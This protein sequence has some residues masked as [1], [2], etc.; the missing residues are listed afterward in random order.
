[1]GSI[2]D[3]TN[4]NGINNNFDYLFDGVATM[5]NLNIK[6]D[7]TLLKADAVLMNA[8]NINQSNVD[9]QNQLDNI[10]LESGTSDAEV[11]QSRT[12]SNGNTYPLLK[13][14][15]NNIDKSILSRGANL[16]D[17]GAV[18]DGV[19]DDTDALKSML[20][21]DFNIFYIPDKKY[22]IKEKIEIVR[23]N[24]KIISDG[25]L[26]FELNGDTCF[27]V[28]G[29]NVDLILKIDGNNLA[30][31]GIK[32]TGTNI[33]VEKSNLYNFYSETGTAY[34]VF[35]NNCGRV[36]I[37]NNNISSVHSLGNGTTGDSIGASRGVW[38]TNSQDNHTDGVVIKD[39]NIDGIIGEEGDAIH[40]IN[41]LPNP[42][43]KQMV[44]VV[45]GNT[46]NNFSRRGIKI[47]A[48]DVQVSNNIFKEN[49]D[50]STHTARVIDVI[51]SSDVVVFNNY[52]KT[53]SLNSIGVTTDISVDSETLVFSNVFT[54]LNA[55]TMLYLSKAKNVTFNSNT[56]Y[57]V[58]RFIGIDDSINVSFTNNTFESEQTGGSGVGVN[59]NSL[60]EKIVFKSNLFN[61]GHFDWTFQNRSPNSVI[62]DNISTTE[63][64]GI[65]TFES[66]EG[67]LY[68][69]NVFNGVEVYGA[70]ST[71][72][73]LKSYIQTM[74]N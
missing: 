67:S 65:R 31:G 72:H 10:I 39:N 11:V 62:S 7:A 28:T 6:A 1:M 16:I 53:K 20:E 44:S 60:S 2:W 74:V 71:E 47:Q 26:N 41:G 45:T 23:S 38:V 54:Q 58:G 13:D 4:R 49:L 52:V 21:S 35:A 8:Q 73:T 48:S 25:V 29:D 33:T 55:G 19:T 46:I 18:G 3:R 42:H 22:L 34:G 12:D 17:F 43:F 59:I 24:F 70:G 15:L 61:K 9:V 66:A 5:N 57:T 50:D 30:R 27:T 68:L 56:F 40:L 36:E 37:K 64:D 69:N 63:G 32:V 14:R 51:Y